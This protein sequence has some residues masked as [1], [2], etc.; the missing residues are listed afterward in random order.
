MGDGIGELRHAR[1]VIAA[2]DLRKAVAVQL[3]DRPPRITTMFGIW[4]AGGV[5]VPVNPRVPAP[6][7][8]KVL[9]ATAP[10]VH[11]TPDGELVQL[12][13]SPRTYD[14]DTAFVEDGP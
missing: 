6:E 3:G 14:P 9:T 5:F 2:L 12:D 4:L 8:A 1:F 7:V 11:I 10:A 13:N